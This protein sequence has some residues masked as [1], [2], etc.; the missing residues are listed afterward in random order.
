[1]YLRRRGVCGGRD[2]PYRIIDSNP[3]ISLII[4]FILH[5]YGK[6]PYIDHGGQQW[7]QDRQPAKNG[8]MR[9]SLA[10]KKQ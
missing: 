6:L 10:K 5:L 8:S 7:R 3:L 9:E 4:S 1:M 2:G